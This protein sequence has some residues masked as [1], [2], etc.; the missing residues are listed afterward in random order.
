MRLGRAER[1]TER[2]TE[3]DEEGEGEGEGGICEHVLCTGVYVKD[4]HQHT[5]TH[6]LRRESE[7]DQGRAWREE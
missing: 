3:R 1:E 2:E 5:R 7:S 4:T 6:S